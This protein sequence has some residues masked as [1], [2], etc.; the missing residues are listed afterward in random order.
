MSTLAGRRTVGVGLVLVE[1]AQ[2]M[3]PTIPFWKGEHPSRS[4]DLG[5]AVG[6]LRAPEHEDGTPGDRHHD[7]ALRDPP[8]AARGLRHDLAVTAALLHL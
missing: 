4:W 3:S 1:D 8:A 6:R 5:V 2:G 7:R